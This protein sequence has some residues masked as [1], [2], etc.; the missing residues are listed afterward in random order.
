MP[1]PDVSREMK[2]YL[3]CNCWFLVPVS[4]QFWD[5]HTL[6]WNCEWCVFSTPTENSLTS[7]A[8]TPAR[9]A[10]LRCRCCVR[11]LM[12]ALTKSTIT[13][14]SWVF[15][16]LL[17]LEP[18]EC[19]LPCRGDSVSG[20]AGGLTCPRNQRRWVLI[21]QSCLSVYFGTVGVV[22]RLDNKH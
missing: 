5:C 3:I 10:H 22:R 1:S 7:F 8:I 17:P 2:W 6:V 21:L 18:S 13:K 19:K 20:D 9:E 14:S 12:R 11:A 4:L 16:V 15:P